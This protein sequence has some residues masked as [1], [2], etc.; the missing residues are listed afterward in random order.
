MQ[1]FEL[2]IVD[3]GSKDNSRQVIEQ[4]AENNKIRVVY[5]ANKGLPAA[6]NTALKLAN[7]KYIVRLDADDYFIENALET[8]SSILEKNSNLGMVFGDWFV[9]D[10][11]GVIVEQ[12]Q[13][14]NF[15]EVTLLDQPAHGACTMF[16]TECL[17]KLDGYDESLTRQDGYELWLRFIEH[18]EVTNINV[19][20]FYYRRHGNNLTCNESKLLETRAQ[21]LR[22]H[23]ERKCQTKPRSIAIVPVRGSEIDSRSQ[24]FLKIGGKNLI[25]FTLEMLCKCKFL[26]KVIV[27][28]PSPDIIDFIEKKD[29][30]KSI[31]VIRR[32]REFAMI[33]TS[34]KN[35]V[36]HVFSS[37]KDLDDINSFFLV[38]LDTPFKKPSQLESALNVMQIFEVDTVIGVR[39]DRDKYFRHNGGGLVP[40]NFSPNILQLERD[41][42]YKMVPGFVLRSLKDFFCQG[43]T[44]GEKIG[45]VVFDQKS[46]FAIRSEL[47]LAISEALL[48]HE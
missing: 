39:N 22:R 23:A 15:K 1:D 41:Q 34:L 47:D 27:T 44:F 38:T 37:L 29:E 35:T 11:D 28:T 24:P 26:E 9:V 3:D 7:G 42:L 8:L 12:Q 18:F 19:P 36:E 4:Y 2:I 40:V 17:R 10:E 32:P 21:I 31:A 6:N 25:D 33:N 30:Y 43:N 14:F 45:H 5:Q 20:I 46:S 48:K 16:R 13:R